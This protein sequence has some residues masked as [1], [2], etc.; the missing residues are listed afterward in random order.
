MGRLAVVDAAK[1]M[2]TREAAKCRRGH[3]AL[4]VATCLPVGTAAAA[5]GEATPR[6]APLPAGWLLAAGWRALHGWA[7]TGHCLLQLYMYMYVL[8][9]SSYLSQVAT[10]ILI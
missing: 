10:W 2:L 8:Q 4:V 6:H 9:P 5:P 3:P 1:L 7:G